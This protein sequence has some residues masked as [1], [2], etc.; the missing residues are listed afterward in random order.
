ME[1]EK[2]LEEKKWYTIQTQKTKQ[3]SVGL[4]D[5]AARRLLDVTKHATN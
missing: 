3:K 5:F 2:K 1:T 4:G